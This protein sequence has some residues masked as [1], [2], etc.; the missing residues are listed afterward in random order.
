MRPHYFCWCLG[1]GPKLCFQQCNVHRIKTGESLLIWD[2][3][4]TGFA[5]L[6]L[7]MYRAA[8]LCFLCSG[9]RRSPLLWVYIIM[10]PWML[11]VE[12]KI[13]KA[14]RSCVTSAPNNNV[15]DLVR[16][17][18]WGYFLLFFLS[19]PKLVH[20]VASMEGPCED[21]KIPAQTWEFPDSGCSSDRKLDP[22]SGSWLMHLCSSPLSWCAL[23]F[24][25][26]NRQAAALG[27][28]MSSGLW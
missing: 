3:L 6:L 1:C 8:F 9:Y 17:S 19:S 4:S 20:P 24:L 11:S 15:A 23:W 14:S 2:N 28:L 26:A 18:G 25:S 12:Q 7:P 13:R 22:F 5:T 16:I 21:F 10:S 27:L